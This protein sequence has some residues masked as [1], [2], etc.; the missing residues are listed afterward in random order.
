[1]KEYHLRGFAECEFEKGDFCSGNHKYDKNI[2]SPIKVFNKVGVYPVLYG[3]VLQNVVQWDRDASVV[4]IT[5]EYTGSL[6]DVATEGET[7]VSLE[8]KDLPLYQPVFVNEKT[9]KATI[10]K[11]GRQV[12]YVT[13]SNKKDK[14]CI[15]WFDCKK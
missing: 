8:L 9:G 1:M 3:I 11:L 14:F 10:L 6:I 12:G 2:G 7:I 5:K 15:I 4:D 13:K